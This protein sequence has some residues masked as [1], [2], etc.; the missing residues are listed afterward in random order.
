MNIRID[1]HTSASVAEQ[2]AAGIRRALINQEIRVG[3]ALPSARDLVRVNRVSPVAVSEALR[4][5]EKEG[6]II[7]G[8]IEGSYVAAP[9]K[10]Q[11]TKRGQP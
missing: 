8:A 9:S 1:S 11:G 10:D 2:V 3:E 4:A 5:L 7:R 6:M